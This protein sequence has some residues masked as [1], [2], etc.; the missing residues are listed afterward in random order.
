MNKH[1]NYLLNKISSPK[2]LKKLSIPEMEKL[3]DEI[4]TLILEKDAA[5]GGHLGPDLGIVETTIAYHYVF[6]APKDKIIWDVSH[7][8]YPHK[9][10]TGRA[11]AWLDPDKYEKVTPYSNPEE[12][13]YDYFAV[14]HTSTSVALATGMARARDMLGEHENITA[15]IGD[16]SL[17]GGL[18][19]EGFNNA[20]DEKHNLIIVVNDNQMSIDDNVGGVVT[21]LKKLRESNGQ[22][23]DNPFTA[24]GLDYKYVGQGNDIKAMI[25][26]FKSIKDID[27]P[28]VL[29]INTLK[30]KGY[31]PAIE[32][33]ASHHWVLPFDLK[34]DKT[35]VPA[36]KT[37]NPTTVV[38][39][40]LKKH[41]EN[42]E[43]ILAIN[44]AIPGVFG[45]GEIKNKYPKNYKDVGIAEQESVA[46]A[47][48]A[49]KEGITPILFENSTFLQRA[50]D[51]LSHD[52]AANDLPVVMIVA[53]G[54]ISS[55]SKTHLGVFDQV[56]ISNLPNWIYLAPTALN[57]E[58][59]MIEWAIKQKKHPVAIKMPTKPVPEGDKITNADYSKIKYDIKPGKNVA[60]LALGDMYNMLGKSVAKKTGAS[61][62]NPISAN[63]LDSTTLDILAKKNK[64][65]VTIEDNI[66]D[67]GFGEKVASYLGDKDV[68]VLNYGQK[69]IYT[70][71]VPLKE[72]LKDNH[73]T[74]DQIVEDIK[75]A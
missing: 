45:L 29:H 70:D 8:T 33:E 64:V 62:T 61:L 55:Q 56:M 34:T 65:I 3:A 19:F 50:Y 10:L 44:A 72:T 51:Q 67:G 40:F 13:P 17:T 36:P 1:P 66:L 21:A 71:Q 37:P 5:K 73:M 20:A 68:K 32:N 53:G 24:M 52:V 43:N 18:A 35:T 47:A 15:L 38:L 4:R 12:S 54:G 39:D 41:I 60:V 6:D 2:D 57:E 7:Q 63:I 23:A 74:T 11:L 30:G 31:E 27:Y 14:G 48:G 49:V 22:T 16:G 46:F 69:R 25:D 28:I 42:Q 59:A 75:N 58:K 26:A 9:M